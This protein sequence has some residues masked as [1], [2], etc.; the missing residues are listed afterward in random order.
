MPRLIDCC[1]QPHDAQGKLLEEP[2][3]D[4]SVF[5]IRLPDGTRAKGQDGRL[6]AF[7]EKSNAQ[8]EADNVNA[9]ITA[10]F[11]QINE[12]LIAE[13]LDPV[14]P[15]FACVVPPEP[16]AAVAAQKRRANGSRVRLDGVLDNVVS[17]TTARSRRKKTAT[18]E[19][20]KEQIKENERGD[21]AAK[22]PK[23]GK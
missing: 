10:R 2:V 9:E 12:E 23:A 6:L 22:P 21:G 8:A 18:V 3:L 20:V 19:E 16:H 17:E 14:E 4:T 11:E 1:D 15:A 5:W 7:K 13:G